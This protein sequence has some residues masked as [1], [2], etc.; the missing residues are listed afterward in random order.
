MN[1]Q[2][3]YRGLPFQMT[4]YKATESERE[5]MFLRRKAKVSPPIKPDTPL[6]A[7]LQFFGRHAI[8]GTLERSLILDIDGLATA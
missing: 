3:S 2:P 4:A 5:A 1:S 6:P 7:D 8:P